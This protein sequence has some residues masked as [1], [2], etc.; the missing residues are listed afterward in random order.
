MIEKKDFDLDQR[1]VHMTIDGHNITICF[2][3]EYNPKLASLVKET[4]ID[5]FLRK[6]GICAEDILA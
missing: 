2:S 4:L 6:N 3:Q 5:S 1:E